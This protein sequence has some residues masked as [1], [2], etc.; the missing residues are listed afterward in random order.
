RDRENYDRRIAEN[1]ALLAEHFGWLHALLRE[2]LAAHLGSPCAEAPGLALPGFHVWKAPMIITTPTASIHFDLQHTLV[3]LSSHQ[4][5]FQRKTISFTMAV[6]VP[7][8]GAG[9]DLWDVTYDD[10]RATLERTQ[11]WP[12]TGP[13]CHPDLVVRYPYQLGVLALHDGTRLHRI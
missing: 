1:N 5:P 12:D 8:A 2:A 7:K 9:L 11:V 10:V 13:L 3:G 4:R 6:R